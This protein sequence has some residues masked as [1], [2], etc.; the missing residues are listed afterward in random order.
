MEYA[1]NE[2]FFDD[3]GRAGPHFHGDQEEQALVGTDCYENEG[4]GV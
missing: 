1:G 3:S 4:E 2:R